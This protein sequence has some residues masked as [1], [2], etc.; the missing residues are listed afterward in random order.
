M[1]K[2]TF[3]ITITFISLAILACSE[4]PPSIRVSNERTTKAN[5]QIKT[6]NNTINHNDVAG[7][8]ATNYQDV[9]EGKI[10]VTAEIQNETVSPITTFNASND[11][12]YTIVIVNSN[13]PVLKVNVSDK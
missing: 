9:T 12:N 4:E 10:D 1:K 6:V 8:T 11:N 3:Y 7:G 2:I 5:V 13:P